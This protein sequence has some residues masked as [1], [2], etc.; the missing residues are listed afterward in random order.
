MKNKILLL[1]TCILFYSFGLIAD[2]EVK[3]DANP[4][5]ESKE[6]ELVDVE[7][8]GLVLKKESKGDPVFYIQTSTNLLIKIPNKI[9][10]KEIDLD[11]FK[12]K[13]VVAKGKGTIKTIS[14]KGGD[15]KKPKIMQLISLELKVAAVDKKPEE[16]KKETQGD[17]DGD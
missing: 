4:K 3:K 14:E 6:K 2:D 12:D 5:E 11:K 7:V 10:D 1:L 13:Q 8:S 16:K 9:G 17:G 15:V